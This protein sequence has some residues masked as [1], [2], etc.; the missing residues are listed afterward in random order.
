MK[1][2]GFG[3]KV[4]LFADKTNNPFK[5]SNTSLEIVLNQSLDNLL[6]KF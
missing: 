2:N 3:C 6:L 1:E 4:T 5:G